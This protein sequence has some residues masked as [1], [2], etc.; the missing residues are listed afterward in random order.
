MHYIKKSL[1]M[2]NNE[3]I[4]IYALFNAQAFHDICIIGE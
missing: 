1:K 4:C 3:K 2:I